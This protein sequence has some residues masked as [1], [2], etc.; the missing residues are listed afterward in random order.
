MRLKD[1]VA[2]VT[3]GGSGIGEAT[4]L[5]FVEEGAKVAVVDVVLE[6]ANNVAEA[7]KEKGG[8]A[9]VYQANI[10]KKDEVD[11]MV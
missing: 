4:V 1:R 10:V 5:R 2:I 8:E 7:V 11:G 3:G 9:L 6:G